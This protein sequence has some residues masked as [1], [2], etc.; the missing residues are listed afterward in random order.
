MGHP[1][2]TRHELAALERRL[3]RLERRS[4]ERRSDRLQSVEQLLR[5]LMQTL[6]ALKE[7]YSEMASRAE[8]QKSINDLR[9]EVT[10]D[11]DINNSAKVM[12]AGQLK[13]IDDQLKQLAEAGADNITD[14]DLKE[15]QDSIALLRENNDGLAAAI[16]AGTPKPADPTSDGQPTHPI[17]EEQPQPESQPSDAGTGDTGTSGNTQQ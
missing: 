17:P 5:K 13:I 3:D 14:E 1:Y 10:R 9:N 16:P 11:R 15:L 7:G 6:D 2:V 8:T 12:M 4:P